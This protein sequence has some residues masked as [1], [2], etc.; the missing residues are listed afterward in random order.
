MPA[1]HEVLEPKILNISSS[2]FLLVFEISKYCARYS[3]RKLT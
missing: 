2:V 1:V 3:L